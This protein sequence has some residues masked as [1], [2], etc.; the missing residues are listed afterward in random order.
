MT[1]MLLGTF[2]TFIILR[3]SATIYKF[4]FFNWKFYGIF[5]NKVKGG[6]LTFIM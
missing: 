3:A 1:S 2:K 4:Q 6:N 5:L